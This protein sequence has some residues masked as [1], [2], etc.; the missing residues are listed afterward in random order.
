MK[1]DCPKCKTWVPL[2]TDFKIVLD[3]LK[4]D[5]TFE[6]Q[7]CGYRWQQTPEDDK[8]VYENTRKQV[9]ENST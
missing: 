4:P 3:S 7:N 6:C 5:R 8:R 9:E 1:I 2:G